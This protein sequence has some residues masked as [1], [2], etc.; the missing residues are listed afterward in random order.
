MISKLKIFLR[1]FPLEGY[2]WI[3][4]LLIL[5]LINT[6]SVHFSLCPFYN[7]G[8]DFCPGC[9]LGRSIHHFMNLDF[10]GSFNIHPLGGLAFLIL[11]FRIYSMG[12]NSMQ[13][14][15]TQLSY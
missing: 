4:A 8:I 6:D 15:K 14:L 5:F 11:L 9:G 13:K 3:S 1:Y 10:V 2:I 12:K 7:L